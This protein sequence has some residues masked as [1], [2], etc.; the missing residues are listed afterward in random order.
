MEL[1]QV[2]SQLR[3]HSWVIAVGLF[4]VFAVAVLRWI[5][6][7]RMPP[8]V[9]L[10]SVAEPVITQGS[11]PVRVAAGMFRSELVYVVVRRNEVEVI[12]FANG[13][14]AKAL[15]GR[16]FS[17]DRALVAEFEPLE[18]AL[19]RSF[20]PLGLRKWW[21]MAPRVLLAL[22]AGEDR[23]PTRIEARAAW[24]ACLSAG[25]GEI[26]ML[27]AAL[28]EHDDPAAVFAI[29]SSVGP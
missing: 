13:T 8:P 10:D 2:L 7:P 3:Q 24:E 19:K 6:G 18:A 21:R 14:S 9:G 27:E 22:V 12:N 5:A 11:G 1:E 23:R 25:A 4:S 26:R 28:G 16:H 17:T 29:A 20:E 15:P